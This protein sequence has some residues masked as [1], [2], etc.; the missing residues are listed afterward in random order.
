MSK[1]E[2]LE[3]NFYFGS[4]DKLNPF[5]GLIQEPIFFYRTLSE[6]EI[7]EHHQAMSGPQLQDK[8]LYR[9]LKEK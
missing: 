5:C 4:E 2:W 8:S 6:N 7:Y 9:A 3:G 1:L